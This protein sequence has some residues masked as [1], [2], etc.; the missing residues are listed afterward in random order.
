MC[1]WAPTTS[2][3]YP[4]D[5]SGLEP[6]GEFELADAVDFRPVLGQILG[7]STFSS[8][9]PNPEAPIN[10]S[11]TTAGAVSSPFS[12]FSKSFE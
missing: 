8:A 11:D 5:G 4:C 9:A 1:L 3:G 10:L 12:Y 2:C 7:T 6:D